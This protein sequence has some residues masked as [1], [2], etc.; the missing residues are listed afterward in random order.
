ML[1]L[2]HGGL[3]SRAKKST[4]RVQ[5]ELGLIEINFDRSGGGVALYIS[6]CSKMV[7]F[8]QTLEW[9]LEMIKHICIYVIY[10]YVCKRT[11]SYI[12]TTVRKVSQHTHIHSF[13]IVRQTEG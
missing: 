6:G 4:I 11:C 13:G 1:G 7:L 10:T 3:A 2:T 8:S 12:H 5:E 9:K